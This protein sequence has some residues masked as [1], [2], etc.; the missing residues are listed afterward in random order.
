ML[1]WCSV[2]KRFTYRQGEQH[3][4]FNGGKSYHGSSAVQEGRLRGA[5]DT[6]HFYFFCPSCPGQEIMRVLDYEV[7]QEQPENKYTDIKPKAA[8]GFTLA[9]KIH[10]QRCGKTDFTKIGNFGWQGGQHA[11]A[12]AAIGA[13][14]STPVA[15]RAVPDASD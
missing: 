5:T 6:D 1:N 2:V 12:L 7:R 15:L 10:C 9:F 11:A 3:E 4:Q 13:E 14:P 8:K